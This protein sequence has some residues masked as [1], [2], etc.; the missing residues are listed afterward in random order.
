MNLTPRE[1]AELVAFAERL[2]RGWAE[3]GC[4]VAQQDWQAAREALDG[5]ADVHVDAT[6]AGHD[7]LR[8]RL[9]LA[10]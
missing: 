1:R 6:D 4:A 10:E 9:W 5:I 2:E 8:T 3:F 7:G